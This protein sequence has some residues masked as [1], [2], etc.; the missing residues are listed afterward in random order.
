LSVTQSLTFV[1]R[2]STSCSVRLL[3]LPLLFFIHHFCGW[4]TP[5]CRLVVL[6][7]CS[8]TYFVTFNLKLTIHEIILLRTSV[9]LV[10]SVSLY[11]TEQL[12]QGTVQLCFFLSKDESCDNHSNPSSR[13]ENLN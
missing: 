6:L 12:V 1:S 11:A 5:K 10:G 2:S 4:C 13:H 9:F 7:P 3:T 8:F